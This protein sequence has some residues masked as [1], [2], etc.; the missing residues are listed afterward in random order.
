MK[1]SIKNIL[2]F[3]A[4]TIIISSCTKDFKEVNTN[5]NTL[6]ETRPEL[7]LESAIFG[8]KTA[9]Q[10]REH[11]LI[12]EMMQ[13]HATVSNSDEIHR[14]I[15]RPSESDYMWNVWYTQ[16]TNIKDVYT[17]AK[18]L[19]LLPNQGYNASYMG[20]SRIME[21]WVTSLITDTYGD[22]PYTEANRG[23]TDNIFQP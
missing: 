1:R 13:V 14:Y 3:V 4:A 7:L 10:T 12:H 22:V 19:A 15:I 6:P 23:R 20:I 16:L 21:A 18:N 17:S 8:L 9:T 2:G 5:P 11:R